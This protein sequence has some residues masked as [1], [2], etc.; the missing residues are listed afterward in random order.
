MQISKFADSMVRVLSPV[1]AFLSKIGSGILVLMVIITVADVIG[2]KLFNMPVKG[3]Y[4]LGEMLLVVV[5]FL[6][7]PNTE[8]QD[9]NVTID[10]LFVRFGQKAKRIIES[11]MYVLFLV[12]SI[13]F[14]WQLFVLASDEASG[15]FTTTTLNIPTSPVIFIGS[16]GCGILTLVVFA[17]LIILMCGGRK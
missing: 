3:A 6:N 4:E 5:V 8:M 14:T 10:I 9:G 2:R 12:I 7:L 17:R 1:T 16:F 13:L 11:L 15:G